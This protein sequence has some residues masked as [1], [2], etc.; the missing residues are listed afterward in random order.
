MW[1]AT[2]DTYSESFT[3]TYFNPRP[4]CGGRRGAACPPTLHPRYF[5]PR[6]PCGGR[7]GGKGR[8]I[9]FPLISIHAPRVGGDVITPLHIIN[10][11]NISIHAPRVGGDY[12]ML[13]CNRKYAI[14]IHAPRVGGDV[15]LLRWIG[16]LFQ[17]SIHAP[18]VGGDFCAMGYHLQGKTKEPGPTHPHCGSCGS[19]SLAQAQ[20]DIQKSLPFAVAAVGIGPDLAI[21]REPEELHRTTYRADDISIR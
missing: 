12:L 8:L 11:I 9:I 2:S 16:G 3:S 1:G 7:H 5:N 6:P 18:R 13:F 15:P 17:I 10:T 19:G 21:R 14:S 20:I 4:P